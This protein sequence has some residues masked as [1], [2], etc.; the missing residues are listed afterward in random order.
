MIGAFFINR[1]GEG[2]FYRVLWLCHFLGWVIYA[3]ERT[4]QKTFP[5]QISV[6]TENKK[7]T[8]E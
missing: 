7:K 5:V 8:R 3:G 1:C 4:L 2:K 6:F